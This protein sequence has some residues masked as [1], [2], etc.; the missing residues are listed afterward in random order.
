VKEFLSRERRAFVARNVEE[1][2]AAYD[3][4]LALGFRVVPVTVVGGTRVKGFD[5]RKLRDAL[6]AAS[7][8]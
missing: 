5:E 4:L 1:D 8:P 2:H 6:A 3:E 7:E